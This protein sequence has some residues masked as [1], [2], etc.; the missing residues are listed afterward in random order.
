M[1][2][3]M[4][5]IDSLLQLGYSS[6]NIALVFLVVMIIIYR[7]FS[8]ILSKQVP[9]AIFIAVFAAAF[10]FSINYFA[11]FNIAMKEAIDE[12]RA[13]EQ[14]GQNEKPKDN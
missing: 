9:R 10:V 14:N 12:K 2:L 7:S 1:E 6:I 11:G 4:Q 13:T 3:P 8:K 5:F